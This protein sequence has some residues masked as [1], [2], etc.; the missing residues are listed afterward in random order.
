MG[1]I[2]KVTFAGKISWRLDMHNSGIHGVDYRES[3][4]T[5]G[6]EGRTL[7]YISVCENNNKWSVFSDP[8]TYISAQK[9]RMYLH[10][11]S[12]YLHM[13]KWL[14]VLLTGLL[15]ALAKNSKFPRKENEKKLTE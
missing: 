9:I 5:M 3:D 15:R 6:S 2:S 13:Y 11:Y 8:V 14:W 7:R 12:M 1:N 10:M 4:C